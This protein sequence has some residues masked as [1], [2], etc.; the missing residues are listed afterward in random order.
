[1]T[2]RSEVSATAPGTVLRLA[3]VA[4]GLGH[5]ALGLRAR[6]VAWLVTEVA[7][8]ALLAYLTIGLGDTTWYLVPFLAGIAFLAAWI[9]QA[10]AAYGRAQRAQGAIG[11]TPPRSPAAAVAWLCLPLLV[12]GTGFW[13]VAGAAA[14]PAAVVD[15][16]ETAW[17]AAAGGGTL[18]AS[19][20]LDVASQ[21]ASRTAMQQLTSL[22]ATGHLASDCADATA[23]LL[24]DVR[25]TIAPQPGGSATAVAQVVTY[26]RRPS[27][28]LGIFPA[29]DLVAVPQETILVLL[30]R[31]DAAPLPGGLDVGAQRWLIQGATTSGSGAR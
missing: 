21:R 5:L 11:P 16:F 22:C 15:R 7:S 28:F 3:L 17:P 31:T 13:L 2:V 27:R 19:L 4:W 26:E 18:D 10:V 24:R 14:G 30:L 12:W 23:N 9:V 25:F 6:A 1:M 8:A 29:T 20:G